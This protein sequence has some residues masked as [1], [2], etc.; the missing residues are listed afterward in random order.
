MSEC[1]HT[2]EHTRKRVICLSVYFI[3]NTAVAEIITNL[4]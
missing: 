1:E 2:Y 4:Q 3:F